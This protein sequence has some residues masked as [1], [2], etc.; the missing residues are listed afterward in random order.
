MRRKAGKAGVC[1]NSRATAVGLG[2]AG[3]PAV[4]RLPAGL[5]VCDGRARRA[6]VF[7]ANRRRGGPRITRW[8]THSGN[9][10]ANLVQLAFIF[11]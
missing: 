2:G 7:R 8:V 4:R 11:R 9:S 6:R 5:P 3:R 1:A 10:H